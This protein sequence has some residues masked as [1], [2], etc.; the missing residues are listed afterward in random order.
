MRHR[1]L[2]FDRYVIFW[3][4]SNK[5]VGLVNISD[6]AIK[7]G[8]SRSTV[9]RMIEEGRLTVYKTDGKKLLNPNDEPPL[10]RKRGKR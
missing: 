2:K 4:M 7:H 8:I 5:P 9:H 10:I 6:Y 3:E 1:L